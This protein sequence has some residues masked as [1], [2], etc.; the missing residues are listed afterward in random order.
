MSFTRCTL[1]AIAAATRATG[2]FDQAWPA[3][4]IRIVVPFPPGGGTDIIARET[5]RKVAA[6]TAVPNA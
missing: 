3:K 5:S 4:P 6:A 1:V 2:A